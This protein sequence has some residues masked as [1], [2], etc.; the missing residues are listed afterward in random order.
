MTFRGFIDDAPH[1]SAVSGIPFL[2]GRDALVA[3]AKEPG[4]SALVT[5]G[6]NR[7]RVAIAQFVV[8]L[9][10]P[11]ATAIDPGAFLG[12]DVQVCPGTVLMPGS[13]VIT[14]S[15]IGQNAIVNTGATVDH[16]CLIGDG[17]HIAP[18]VHVA[19]G[20]VVERGA[21]IGIGACVAP[22]VRIG[23]HSIIGAGTVVIRDVSARIVAAGNPG[24]KV[25]TLNEEV[26]GTDSVRTA[27]TRIDSAGTGIAAV[28]DSDRRLLGVVTDGDIRRAILRGCNLDQLVDSIMTSSP[29]TVRPSTDP[30][31]IRKLFIDLEF[32]QIPVVDDAGHLLDV[33]LP[34]DLVEARR[35]LE[36]KRS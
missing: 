33:I 18:G 7:T 16:D 12:S 13:I 23:A 36:R 6:D 9:G 15:R 32:K 30:E 4:I 5:I 17:V 11:L 26:T 35:P 1:R 20:A 22:G 8:S 25:R 34:A 19:G 24:R 14:G 10:M 31:E 29:V 2:G 28:V 27:M 21:F 3:I